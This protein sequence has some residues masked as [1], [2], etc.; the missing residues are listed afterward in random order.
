LLVVLLPVHRLV[1][2]PGDLSGEEIVRLAIEA[3]G[4]ED[5]RKELRDFSLWA[6]VIVYH[7][8]HQTDTDVKQFYRS[9]G[10]FRMDSLGGVDD[11]DWQIKAYDRSTDVAWEKAGGRVVEHKGRAGHADRE[12]IKADLVELERLLRYF[13]LGNLPGEGVSFSRRPDRE[14]GGI[15]AHVV[16]RTVAPEVVARN[17]EAEFDRVILFFDAASRQLLGVEI[18]AESRKAATRLNVCFWGR[19]RDVRRSGKALE[20]GPW[21]PSSVQ[22]F[23]NDLIKTRSTVLKVEVNSGLLTDDFFRVPR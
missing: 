20:D 11:R 23:E 21:I 9:D 15:V 4:A 7:E 6:E 14:N 1:S 13:F 10:R 16:E 5:L 3:Q 22:I 8:G 17:P 12:K 19:L 18:P 2:M